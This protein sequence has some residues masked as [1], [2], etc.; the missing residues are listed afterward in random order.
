MM[1]KPTPL[2]IL[3]RGQVIEVTRRRLLFMQ[4]LNRRNIYATVSLEPTNREKRAQEW[5]RHKALVRTG[6]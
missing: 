1:T 2:A 5:G 6:I 3:A 4:W